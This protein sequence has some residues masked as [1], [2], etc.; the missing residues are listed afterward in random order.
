MS[1]ERHARV[2]DIF[3]AVADRPPGE[4]AALLDRLCAGDATLRREVEALLAHDEKPALVDTP[5]DAARVRRAMAEE[6]AG[7]G[8]GGDV[9]SVARPAGATTAALPK[10]VDGYE[11]VG[12]L[13]QGGMG[14][15]YRARQA[16]PTRLVALKVI[17]PALLTPSL[18]NRFEFEAQVLAELH[19]PGIAEIYQA[20]TADVHGGKVPFFAMELIAGESLTQHT[21]AKGLDRHA[22]LALLRKVCEAVHH[23]HQKGVI[24]RDLKPGNILVTQ[25][26]E[27]KILDFGVARTTTPEL[28][29]QTLVTQPGQIVGTLPYMSPEQLAGDSRGV[30]ARSDIYALGVIAYELLGGRLPH[31]LTG[32]S[33]PEAVR[34]VGSAAPPPLGRIDPALR[35]DVETIVAK[36]MD[37]DPSRRYVSAA[38]LAR[39]IE[40]YLKG[41]AIEARRDSR[42]Y[43]L[44]KA[45][46]RHRGAVAAAIAFV[47]VLA[48]AT[49]VSLTFAMGEARQRQLTEQ[50]AEETRK[51]ARFQQG[52]LRGLDVSAM[53]QGL[54]SR[55]HEEARATL[56]RQ[57]IGEW[58]QRRARTAEEIETRLAA[59]EETVAPGAAADAARALLATYVLAPAG[60]AMESQF[61][62]EPLVRAQ[63]ELALGEAYLDLGLYGQAEPHLRTALTLREGGLGSD[64]LDTAEA[65]AA[66]GAA[67]QAQGRPAEAEALYREALAVRSA[68][69]GD[70]HA[71]A[72]EAMASIASALLDRGDYAASEAMFGEALTLLRR[73]YGERHER[74]AL[75]LSNFGE[76][77]G[78]EGDLAGSEAAHREALD[79]RREV[80]PEGHRE[81]ATSLNNLAHLLLAAGRFTEALPLQREAVDLF[82]ALL[83]EDHPNTLAARHNLA[84]IQRELRQLD[85]AEAGFRA[86]IEAHRK[87]GLDETS[88]ARSLTGLALVLQTRGDHAG[89]EP[90]LREAADAFAALGENHP[91]YAQILNNLASMLHLQRRYDEAEPLYRR[92]LD[93][94]RDSPGWEHVEVALMLN[95]LGALLRDTERLAAAESEYREAV[96][97]FRRVAPNH[98]G[99]PA[100]LA[101]FARVLHGLER[102]DEAEPLFS[103]ALE[104]QTQNQSPG[105]PQVAGTQARLGRT[106][107]KLG[108]YEEAERLL[109]AA[110]QTL[111]PDGGD[112][113]SGAATAAAPPSPNLVLAVEGLVE[114]YEAWD[115][116]EP[117]AGHGAKADEWRTRTSAP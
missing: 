80:W 14:T 114:L 82:R 95:N 61:A 90:L 112:A 100:S 40:R 85:E 41:E 87:A 39:E 28:R 1:R 30:D 110:V 97:M 107:T 77:L 21:A 45:I 101:G 35:G 96:A 47:V 16:M 3:M 94:R 73:A 70:E 89:S 66:L 13:G 105:S 12:L 69:L 51:V 102:Y 4:R 36:A 83:G 15:V 60:Q 2:S 5:I 50:R 18:V 56:E 86:V 117:G 25:D 81:T 44:R 24:H 92:A 72:A 10:R 22:R 34:A 93:I 74:V 63:L 52:M 29:T 57:R 55:L 109:L 43:V 11:I 108:R 59:L 88:L 98:P 20:G 104:L 68:Q 62:D 111:D 67:L 79:I 116:A 71:L 106:L 32:K 75:A 33:L 19:H 48:G 58:P 27:P 23:A 91:D 54:R 99:L 26:G 38:E 64:H 9:D 76:L 103:E 78:A 113:A 84:D 65:M 7:G 115:A 53:G 49:A 37:K 46:A 42:A 6:L 17:N 8:A 31:D